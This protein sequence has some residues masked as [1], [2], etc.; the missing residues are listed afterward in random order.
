[1]A[2]KRERYQQLL[3]KNP[4]PTKRV[5][6]FHMKAIK[7]ENLTPDAL[8]GSF[9]RITLGGDYR[10]R[11]EVG[12]G[13][14][15][16]GTRAGKQFKTTQTGKLGEGES[17]YFRSEFG[18]GCA[19]A[20]RH[21][22]M[23]AAVR[24]VLPCGERASNAPPTHALASRAACVQHPG[25]LDGLVRAARDGGVHDRLHAVLQPQEEPPTCI[26]RYHALGARAGFRHPGDHPQG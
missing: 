12:K 1:M 20:R 26:A 6:Q 15:K 11:E 14:V 22:A 13:L 2:A 18:G 7:V 24:R 17:H 23:V 5:F 3:Q 9:L 4:D 8:A 21:R 10:E 25:V 19:R 16:K